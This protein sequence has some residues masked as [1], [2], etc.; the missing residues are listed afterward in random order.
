MKCGKKI[1]VSVVVAVSVAM[2]SSCNNTKYLPKNESLYVGA[3][4][5]LKA[6]QLKRS[7]RKAIKAEL[8]TLPRPK[9]NTSIL[10][11]RPK[12]WLWNIGGNPK[13]KFSIRRMIKNLGEPPVLLS[14]V[15]LERNNKVLQNNLE[16]NGYFNAE[17]AGEISNKK[18]RATAIYNVA[19]G[20]LYTINDVIFRADS[21]E[22][23]KAILRTRRRTFLKK[24]K[25]FDLDIV[26][27]ERIRID[28]R[29]KNLGFYFHSPDNIIVD[30]DSTIGNHKI[31]MYVASK[32]E[33]PLEAR[34]RYRINDVVIY[35]T[36]SI[37]GTGTDTSR[38]YGILYDDYYVVDSSKFYKP[39]LFL[40]AMQFEK[41][42]YYNRREHNATLQRLINL[43][44]FKFVK[45]RFEIAN[46]TTLNAYY[47][48]TPLP[49]KSLRI[50]FG[51]NTK[52]NNLTGS[53][54]TLGFTNRNALRG[55]EILT[56]NFNVGSEV[57]VS[58]N[59]RGYNT[60]RLGADANLAV[61]RFIIPFI[62][63]NPRGGFV[64]RTNFQLGYE[65]LTRQ[66]LY[67]LNS[68]KGALGYTWKES[69][70][71]EHT[72]YPISVQYVQPVKVTPAYLELRKKDSTLQ[73]VIDTQFILGANYSYLMNQ[74]V[75]PR[76]P[77]N[78]F[79]FNG[80]VDISGNIAGVVN[81]GNI[82]GGD[83]ARIFGAPYSQYLKLESDFR[84]YRQLG[85]EAV[86]ASRIDAGIG[87]PYGNSSEIPFIKQFFIG[88]NNS[89]RAFRSRS[90]GPG[91]YQAVKNTNVGFIP[92][93][94]GDIKLELNTELRFKIIKP[95]YGAAFID[96]GNIWLYNEN[97]YKPGS[98]FSKDFLNELAAGTGLGVRVD[99]TIL[100]LR[101]DLA[102]PIRKPWLP[103][104]ERWV[105]KDVDFSNSTWRKDNLIFNLAIGYPF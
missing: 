50:E 79:Y 27:E 8:S 83:T 97:K 51:G 49:K 54:V 91:T 99:I 5:N 19:P 94:S 40:Q 96:A 1:I 44:I 20:A 77:R 55:G 85:N 80:L 52:S 11:L 58:G 101:L 75:G 65:I 102:F 35:P 56:V 84:Y 81:R 45:N 46:D 60:F 38:K 32:P 104:T 22:L 68:F 89:L 26:K 23:Q 3:K 37:N 76:I 82:K 71:K 9:P 7:Q 98:K 15:D 10:G 17:V 61:P 47:Y 74:M 36:Y 103:A 13:K 92:D 2:I 70:Q 31:N 59:F 93:Q 28:E 14:E 72:F 12:L 62:Y 25:P 48:L 6:P 42:E 73:K 4:I 53:Q 64:P 86:W 29:L 105:I 41:G 100:V 88:G 95:V 87:F 30:V 16:N 67:T 90:L 39:R 33:T 57:Q 18:R 78:G 43:G 66:S 21:S 34:K 69:L 63:L 24:N